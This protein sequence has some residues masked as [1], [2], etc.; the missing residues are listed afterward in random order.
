MKSG[1][2][3]YKGVEVKWFTCALDV[4]LSSENSAFG[5]LWFILDKTSLAQG[6]AFGLLRDQEEGVNFAR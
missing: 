6:T 1:C 3:W 4:C 5:E 2:N